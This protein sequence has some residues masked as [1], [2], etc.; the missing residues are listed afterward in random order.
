MLVKWIR[1]EVTARADFD[2]GQR[3]WTRLAEVPGF[4]GQCAGWGSGGDGFEIAHVLSLWADQA[5]YDRFMKGAHEALAAAQESTY[6]KI[7]VRLFQRR[8]D[9]GTTLS[10]IS[11]PGVLRL[12]HCRVRAGRIDHFTEVQ[13]TVWNPG[14]SEAPGFLGGVFTQRG[15]DEFLVVTKWISSAAHA[16]H[17]SERFPAL[18]DRA[19]P[20]GDLD[21]ITGYLVEVEPGWA[22]APAQR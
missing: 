16:G 20:A 12:A 5:G 7:D 10:G 4:L 19:V 3:V 13:T 18:R 15:L 17:Q 11:G 6:R 21:A 1:C 2:R 8:Q 22:V 14:M 9:I